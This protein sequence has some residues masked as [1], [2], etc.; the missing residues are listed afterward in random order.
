RVVRVPRG[1]SSAT[2]ESLVLQGDNA[3]FDNTL[4]IVDEPRQEAT[5]LFIG[6]DRPDDPTG[7]LYYLNRVFVDTPRRTLKVVAQSPTVPVV[8]DPARPTP[9]VI[10]ASEM[11]PE[12]A[13]RLREHARAGSTVLYVATGPNPGETLATLLEAPA[14]AIEESPS[15][16]AL[17]G[18][19]A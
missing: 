16:D 10:L 19:I 7:L 2:A 18:E 4:F 14:R 9:L 5:V 12:N 1:K 6:P 17:L 8:M 15:R 3:A 13:R 11:N